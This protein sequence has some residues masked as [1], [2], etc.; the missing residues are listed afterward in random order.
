M[1]PKKNKNKSLD[2]FPYFQFEFFDTCC[3]LFLHGMQKKW[4]KLDI[5]NVAL[6]QCVKYQVEISG[7]LG[8]AKVMKSDIWK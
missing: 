8:F 4:K 1:W 5:E 2:M 7:I 3:L 6:Y